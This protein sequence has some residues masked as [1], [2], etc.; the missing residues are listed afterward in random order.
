MGA[1]Q[2]LAETG[3][4]WY[5]LDMKYKI[6]PVTKYEIQA[7]IPLSHHD[8]DNWVPSGVVFDHESGAQDYIRALSE[9]GAATRSTP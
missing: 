2:G 1:V 6:V 5:G 8:E 4:N 3:Q 9:S 7:R